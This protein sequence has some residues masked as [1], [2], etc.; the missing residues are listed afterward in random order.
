MGDSQPKIFVRE[1]TGLIRELGFRDQLL[2]SQ[3]IIN[4]LGG[5]VLTAALAPFYFPGA[6]LAFVFLLGAIPAA[7]MAV[8]YAGLS[9]AMPRSGGDYVWSARILGPLYGSVQFIFIFVGTILVG[10]SLSAWSA[11]A[12]GLSQFFLGLGVAFNNQSWISL[13][14]SLGSA[15][16]G[17]P[18]DLLIVVLFTAVGLLGLRVYRW[19]QGISMI[20][21]YIATVAFI[22]TLVGINS[23]TI[24]HTFDHA[25]KVAGSNATYSGIIQQASA[26]GFASSQFNWNNTILAAIP[27]G[28]SPS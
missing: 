22:V 15:S 16:L 4:I 19:F 27:W 12:I 11:V 6:N 8:V 17:Y 24:P 28:S 7:A 21:F 1:A 23:A 14:S 3:L 2:M 13:A 9:A 25:M 10:I 26:Q 20:I 18:I 5:F